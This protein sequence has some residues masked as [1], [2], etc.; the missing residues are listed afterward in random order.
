MNEPISTTP[1]WT[2][3]LLV[4]CCIAAVAMATLVVG[5]PSQAQISTQRVITAEKGV[6]QSTVSGDGTLQPATQDDVNFKT[7]GTLE[8]LY[9]STGQYVFQGE[10]LATLNPQ[11]AEVGVQQAQATLA[12]DEANLQQAEDA[13]ANASS[14]STTASATAAA[15]AS[16]ADVARSTVQ[17]S[18]A[19]TVSV[20]QSPTTAAS[21]PAPVNPAAGSPPT[22]TTGATAVTS[23]TTVTL[24]TPGPS[25]ATH[26]SAAAGGGSGAAGQI[27]SGS[28]APASQSGSG[29]GENGGGGSS[30]GNSSAT[31]AAT[32]AANVA[33]AEATVASARLSVESAEQTLADTR[34]YAPASGTV[35]SVADVQVG[36]TVSAG[37]ASSGTADSGSSSGTGALGGAAGGAGTGSSSASTSA[38][39][40]SALVTIVNVAAMEVVVPFGESDIGK[41]KVGQPATVTVDALSSLELAA[42]V[43]TVSLLG[44]TSSSVTSY[45][46]TIALDQSDAQLKPG[47]SATAQ[48]IVSQAQGAVSVPSTAI[49]QAG[50]QSTVTVRRNGKDVVTPVTTGVVGDSATQILAGV[51][52]GEQIVIT[53]TTN[54]GSS[55]AGSAP[56]GS[57][58]GTLGGGAGGL[59][60]GGGFPSGGFP[61]GGFPSGGPPGVG[62]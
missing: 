10:L 40:S 32:L 53:T 17:S 16:A 38:S 15:Y 35:A 5:P 25:P 24:T 31:S 34:L 44:T 48:V 4:A 11:Q 18:S 28:S 12:S 9:V 14:T 54:A 46:V 43:T 22:G 58:T 27:S 26:P 59:G 13:Q 50:G 23:T 1:A 6:V 8:H 19:Q 47:M 37:S 57:T 30:G 36:D 45:D 20:T 60:G 62:G 51:T 42:H 52:S 41:V 2:R 56:G 49:S 33:S 7:G 55:S 29:A 3:V 39:S 21:G 61:S